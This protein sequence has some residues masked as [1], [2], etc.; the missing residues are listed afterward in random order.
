[1]RKYKSQKA[2]LRRAR[3]AAASVLAAH[4]KSLG[5]TPEDPESAAEQRIRAHQLK[6]SIHKAAEIVRDV[7][8]ATQALKTLPD[9]DGSS[10][11]S[12]PT[13]SLA[14]FFTFASS[15]TRSSGSATSLASSSNDSFERAAASSGPVT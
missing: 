8:G 9:S 15:T 1:M 10:L 5:L 7:R 13:S 2:K 3:A 11:V 4:R 14:S 6:E 12:S